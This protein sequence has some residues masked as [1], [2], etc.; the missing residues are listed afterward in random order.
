[1]DL[2]L[3]DYLDAKFAGVDGNFAEL[4]TEVAS[5]IVAQTT[6]RDHRGLTSIRRPPSTS[7][8]ATRRMSYTWRDCDGT[9]RSGGTSGAATLGHRCGAT[10]PRWGR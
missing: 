7:A 5:G 8:A 9:A 3:R 4:R 10:P 6:L 2:E 1:M